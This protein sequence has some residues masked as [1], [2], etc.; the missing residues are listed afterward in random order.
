MPIPTLAEVLAAAQLIDAKGS[1]TEVE[2]GDI[3]KDQVY[4]AFGN[5]IGGGTT[6]AAQ[7]AQ[8]WAEF[9]WFVA[10]RGG[11]ARA[12][13]DSPLQVTLKPV[14]T[15]QA[16]RWSGNSYNHIVGH[17]Q[18][19]GSWFT[20]QRFSIN[21]ADEIHAVLTTRPNMT[22]WGINNKVPRRYKNYA[23]SAGDYV[24]NI[25]DDASVAVSFAKTVAL[26]ERAAIATNNSAVAT[27]THA[28]QLAI[29]WEDF[30]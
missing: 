3:R 26:K 11:S 17:L 10:C 30:A 12:L 20:L 28:R 2:W 13:D 29:S 1:S 9:L 15:G 19:L 4:T 8:A 5:A 16:V 7:K 14:G 18:G 6:T 23:F 24:S 22:T 25:P 21:F 27:A